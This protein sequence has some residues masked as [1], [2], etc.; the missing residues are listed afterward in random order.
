MKRKFVF[1]IE[2]ST[3]IEKDII[4]NLLKDLQKNDYSKCKY[5]ITK[6]NKHT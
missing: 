3:K 5:S 2:V 6:K 4:E 1:N